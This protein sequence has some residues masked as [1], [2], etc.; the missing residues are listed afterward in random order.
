M[1]WTPGLAR[2]RS[3]SPSCAPGPTT[4]RSPS[5]R[6]TTLVDSTYSAEPSSRPS[7]SLTDRSIRTRPMAI[8]SSSG[9][10]SHR[11]VRVSTESAHAT[12]RRADDQGAGQAGAPQI[13]RPSSSGGAWPRTRRPPPTRARR[14][15]H[16]DRLRWQARSTLPQVRHSSG[17][18][19]H[20][21]GSPPR[22]GSRPVH[23]RTSPTWSMIGP[24]QTGA[25]GP[26]RH[27]S[28][29]LELLV[30]KA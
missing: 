3:R 4:T 30:G 5:Y 9:T 27:T 13:A 12:C 1:T 25:Q 21:P 10:S 17:S 28:G 18:P 2:S 24:L 6:Y 26:G 14:R 20:G 22:A 19:E 7:G 29:G 15:G 16:R 11:A 23:T 8:P